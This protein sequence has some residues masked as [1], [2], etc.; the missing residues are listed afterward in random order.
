MVSTLQLFHKTN[1]VMGQPTSNKPNTKT[2]TPAMAGSNLTRVQVQ[3][4]RVSKTRLTGIT[5][6]RTK[7]V[8]CVSPLVAMPTIT[9]E[10]H[11]VQASLSL[12]PRCK[13]AHKRKEA[14]SIAL[15]RR[16]ISHPA[17]L[18]Q[19]SRPIKIKVKEVISSP[20]ASPSQVVTILPQTK[21]AYRRSK[22]LGRAVHALGATWVHKMQPSAVDHPC[23]TLGLLARQVLLHGAPHR[24]ESN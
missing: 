5:T 8:T 10:N 19:G 22:V 24:L 9:P 7:V 21:G 15:H 18:K 11:L 14:G 17:S 4:R 20:S 1:S 3:A 23:T 6:T 13:Q 2:T 16:P 12:S